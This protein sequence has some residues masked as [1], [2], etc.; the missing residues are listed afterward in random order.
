MRCSDASELM[1]EVVDD[2][3][4]SEREA[5]LLAHVADCAACRAE[6]E[7][8]QQVDRLLAAAPSVS[9]PAEF[10]SMVMARLARRRPA[11]NPWAGALA[12]F[13]GTIALSLLAVLSFVGLAPLGESAARLQPG[14]VTLPQVGRM[15]MGWV[16]AGWE[17]RQA[18]I[19]VVPSALILLYALL[20]LL[21]LGVWL[22]LIAGLQSPLR[23][24]GK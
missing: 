3:A 10:T 14:S 9:P 1:D 15:L 16:Q 12:L 11:H 8:L 18:V 2:H 4:D 21:A 13:A 19:S 5:A 22:G 17:I 24:A 7:V 20:A 23:P 6:W